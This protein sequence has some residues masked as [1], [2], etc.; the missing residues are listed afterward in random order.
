MHTARDALSSTSVDAVAALNG[1]VGAY[2][3]NAPDV[4]AKAVPASMPST[5]AHDQVAGSISERS[6]LELK[7]ALTG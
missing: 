3:D 7:A 2:N 5:A 1:H 4:V 6:R